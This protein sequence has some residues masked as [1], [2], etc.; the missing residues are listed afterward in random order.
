MAHNK[1]LVP[2]GFPGELY[3]FFWDIIKKPLKHLFDDF[4]KGQLYIGRLNVGTT[5][6]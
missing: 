3:Q 2:D 5:V 6:K 1:C 4:V